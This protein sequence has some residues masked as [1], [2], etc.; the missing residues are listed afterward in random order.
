MN[1]LMAVVVMAAVGVPQAALAQNDDRDGRDRTVRRERG[2]ERGQQGEWKQERPDRDREDGWWDVIFGDDGDR[3]DRD[4]ARR[5]GGPAFCRSGA[6]HPVFGRRW[7]VRKGFGLG[8][9]GGL[10][11]WGDIIFESPRRRDVGVLDAGDLIDILGDIVFM[12]LNDQR[13]TLGVDDPLV[14][15][16]IQR[17]AAAILRLRSGGIPIVELRDLDGDRRVDQLRLN[18][19][20]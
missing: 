16:W 17:E 14:G 18:T 12:R 19:R 15:R 1:I 6:G 7:C 10:G 3:R 4:R 2:P 5:G 11:G 8:D 9:R 20:P 13:R